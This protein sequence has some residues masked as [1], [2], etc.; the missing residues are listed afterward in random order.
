MLRFCSLGSGSS[1]NATLVEGL[2]ADGGR[3]TR[4]LIDCG[5]GPRQLAARLA[6]R[7]LAPTDLDAVFVTHEHSDHTAGVLALQR[8]FGVAVWASAGTWEHVRARAPEPPACHIARPGVAIHVG[9]LCLRPFSVPHDA[10]EPLQ[11]VVGDGRHCV[12]ILTDIGEP[13][14]AVA[15][16]LQACD[17]LLLETNHDPD[18]LAASAYPPWLQRRIAGPR[19]HLAN[20]QAADL[21][22]RCR[23]NALRHVIAAHLSVR[24]N[25]PDL[26]LAALAGALSP[27]VVGGT[28]LRVADAD[29]GCDW[30]AMD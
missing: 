5:L 6:L 12:G 7:G 16:A 17:A 14:D 18:L 24:N 30:V 15:Q 4:L 3:P 29:A 26:A 21:L 9:G 20:R 2:S 22:D 11:L 19:G 25:R 27:G 10:S 8:R 13:T 23:H 1:G 28:R